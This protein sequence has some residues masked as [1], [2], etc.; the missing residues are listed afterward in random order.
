MYSANLTVPPSGAKWLSG[1]NMSAIG[2]LARAHEDLPENTD[3]LALS[4]RSE[5]FET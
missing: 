2:N 4:V 5:V 3:I 1:W